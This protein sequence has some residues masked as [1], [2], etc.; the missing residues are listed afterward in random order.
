M[1]ELIKMSLRVLLK[2]IRN[3]KCLT[4]KTS[5]ALI[6]CRTSERNAIELR[7]DFQMAS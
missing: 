3:H 1:R 5:K 4:K 2:L 7:V 6:K